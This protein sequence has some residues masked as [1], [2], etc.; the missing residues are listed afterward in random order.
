MYT[1]KD[2]GLIWFALRIIHWIIGTKLYLNKL[3]TVLSLFTW[4]RIYNPLTIP[5]CICCKNLVMFI[6]LD[7]KKIGGKI[8]FDK[9][10]VIFMT[11]IMLVKKWVFFILEEKEIN[12]FYWYCDL[13]TNVLG[14]LIWKKDVWYWC[15]FDEVV[16]LETSFWMITLKSL[17]MLHNH[18][19]L[20]LLIHFLLQ[21]VW[22]YVWMLC[23]LSLCVEVTKIN[24]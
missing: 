4:S 7:F 2:T 21:L 19:Q 18:E 1:T 9:E 13:S 6:L 20:I 23:L 24:K 22:I 14:I 12:Y 16:E 11:K 8:K 10:T 5:L 3:K 17:L 15:I